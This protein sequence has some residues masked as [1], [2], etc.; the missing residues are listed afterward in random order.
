MDGVFDPRYDPNVGICHACSMAYDCYKLSSWLLWPLSI[1]AMV[2]GNGTSSN[3]EVKT[4]VLRVNFTLRQSIQVTTLLGEID[5]CCRLISPTLGNDPPLV[6]QLIVPPPKNGCQAALGQEDESPRKE[7][8]HFSLD[9]W[10]TSLWF[11]LPPMK[12]PPR[13]HGLGWFLGDLHIFGTIIR[14][15]FC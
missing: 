8:A 14:G 4:M 2:W 15:F 12:H 9:P 13:N 7:D 1:L 6:L 5:L 10:G 3:L 11:S